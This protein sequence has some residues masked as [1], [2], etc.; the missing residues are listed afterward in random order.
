MSTGKMSRSEE[1]VREH[2]GIPSPVKLL[3]TATRK[4]QFHTTVVKMTTIT[5][6]KLL[7][8]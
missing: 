8:K 7:I 4:R 2:T 1:P 5:K 6:L 3:S